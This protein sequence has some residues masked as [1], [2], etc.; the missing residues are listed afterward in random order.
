MLCSNQSEEQTINPINP[1]NPNDNVQVQYPPTDSST[2]ELFSFMLLERIEQLESYV[3]DLQSIVN[4]QQ[5]YIESLCLT[6]YFTF[7]IEVPLPPGVSIVDKNLVDQCQRALLDD[8]FNPRSSIKP[9]FVA[10]KLHVVNNGTCLGAD[11]S[12]SVQTPMNYTTF[13]SIYEFAG[14]NITNIQAQ[15]EMYRFISHVKGN[16]PRY[17]PFVSFWHYMHPLNLNKMEFDTSLPFT[18]SQEYQAHMSE[19]SQ[20]LL[21][22]YVFILDSWP[23]LLGQG[24]L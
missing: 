10:W 23:Y 4:Q 19:A 3:C 9:A 21:K 2:H 1:I 14:V 17:N 11:V 18:Q 13:K 5:T 22:I 7:D 8:I 6:T 20:E 15:Y 16:Y 24:G 12:M